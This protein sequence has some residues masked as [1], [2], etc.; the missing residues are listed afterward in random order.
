MRPLS[1]DE[2][3]YVKSLGMPGRVLRLRPGDTGEPE[4]QKH[5]EV[6]ITRWFR[7]DDLEPEEESSKV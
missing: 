7:R 5:Y 6:Q 1:K 2:Q 4:G 3:V